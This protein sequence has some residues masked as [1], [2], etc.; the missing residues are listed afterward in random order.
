MLERFQIDDHRPGVTRRRDV[1]VVVFSAESRVAVA[2][3]VCPVRI[4]P[5]EF[6]QRPAPDLRVSKPRIEN[7]ESWTVGHKDCLRVERRRQP[8]KIDPDVSVGLFK[9]ATHERQ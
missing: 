8:S 5:K 2:V 3:N 1:E 4:R 7:T 9:S 6:A